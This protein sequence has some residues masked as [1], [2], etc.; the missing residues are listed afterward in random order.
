MLNIELFKTSL[1]FYFI[2]L[3]LVPPTQL[4]IVNDQ[5]VAVTNTVIGP[6]KEGSSVNITCISSGG[7]YF[8]GI[9][10]HRIIFIYPPT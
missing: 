10:Q 8:F 1:T 7:K 5:G 3:F 6:Y 2:F 9:N 4:L